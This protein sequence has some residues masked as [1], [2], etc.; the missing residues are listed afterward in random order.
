MSVQTFKFTSLNLITA[1]PS[2]TANI[3][4]RSSDAGDSTASLT[5]YDATS[6]Q[7]VPLNGKKEAVTTSTLT[8]LRW[9]VLDSAA[10][11][12]VDVY[13]EDTGI[14][15]VGDIQ[16]NTIPADGV[17]VSVGLSGAVKTYTFKTALTPT[18]GEV[19][20]GG[21]TILCAEYLA[22]AI[23]DE[24]TGVSVP[25]D[26]THWVGEGTAPAN[27]Y[28]TA[29]VTTN[30]VTL[31]DIIKCSRLLGWG[32][33]QS[34]TEMSIRQ[35]LGGRDGS[36]LTSIDPGDTE[37]YS[38][39]LALDTEDLLTATLPPLKTGETDA[40]IANGE[41]FTIDINC[42]ASSGIVLKYQVSNDTVNW[43]DGASPIANALDN[44]QYVTPAEH[45]QYVRLSIITNGNTS[46]SALNAKLIV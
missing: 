24:S 44:H 40:R 35:P 1:Q 9:A 42:E 41:T 13:S 3:Y 22:S 4:T 46:A 23:N 7:A 15:A 12:T 30:V 29:T 16:I 18:N 32:L 19:L 39:D 28:V 43:F 11:G 36:L 17:T 20:I 2:A 6:N 26:D 37:H 10:D 45:A 21:S 34:S 31:T 33:A 27:L 25:E 38:G 8:D 5:V 14:A